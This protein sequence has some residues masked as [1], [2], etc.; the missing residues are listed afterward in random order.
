MQLFILRQ[1]FFSERGPLTKTL[2]VMKITAFFLLF[3]CLQLGARGLYGQEKIT[4]NLKSASLETV[5]K[6]IRKQT[7][8]QY[9][10][11]DQWEQEAKKIDI[12]VSN[13][14]LSEVLDLCF[15]D[16]PFSYTIIKKMI[17]I[18]KKEEG[19]RLD[20][21]VVPPATVNFKGRVT[22]EQGE[23]LI[24]ASVELK[25][26]K[27]GTLTDEKGMF[28]LKDVPSDAILAVSHTGYQKKEIPLNG[29]SSLIIILGIAN[30]ILDQVKV[31]AYGTTTQ[32]LSTGNVSTVKAEDIEKQPVSNPLAALEG[33][34]PGLVIIQNSG[35]PGSGFNVQIRG[36][37]SISN[38]TDPLY[39]I[40]GVP[41][42]STPLNATFSGQIIGY[43]SPLSYINPSDIE[44]IEVLKDA[45]ATAIYG[46]RGANG[47]I[48]ITTKKGKTG[49]T[50]VD[51][52][53]YTG[54]EKTTR[55]MTLLNTQQY[56]QMRHEAFNNDGIVP[57]T[58]N[59]RDLL[60]WDTTRYTDWQKVLIGGTAHITNAQASISG[61]NSNTHFFLG[62]GYMRETTVFNGN[63][64]DQKGS[65]H[66]NLS[67][68]SE[69]HKL[70]I[71]YSGSYVQDKDNLITRDITPY[72]TLPPD[73]PSVY[74]SSG[75]LNWG[76]SN[77]LFNNNPYSFLKQKFVSKGN[78]LLTNA[79]LKYQLFS[80][81][82]LKTSLGYNQIQV[83]NIATYPQSSYSPNIQSFTQSTSYFSNYSVKS[84]II[85]PQVEYLRN[86]SGGILNAIF[87]TTF[88]EKIS[89]DQEFSA[90]GFSNEALMEN[91]S[92]ATNIAAQTSAY[93]Q[94]RYSAAFGRINYNWKERYL[95]TFTGRRDGSS[96][97]GPG[98]QFANF[99]S[100]G[101]SW[102][103]TNESF[104]KSIPF[105]SLGK[106][107][108]SYGTAGNDQIP[109]YGFLNTYSSTIY[110][111][112]GNSGLVPTRL[113]NANYSWETIKKLEAAIELGLLRDRL[114]ISAI[115]Y[116]SR[117]SN[118]LVGFSL[119]AITGFPSIQANLPALIQN[120]SWEFML[121]TSNIKTKTVEWTTTAN[122][123]IPRNKLVSYPNL[124]SSSYANT[125][126]IG[127][128]LS[129]QKKFHYIGV[130][131]QGG[132]YSFATKN[133]NGLPSYPVDLQ[134]V[135]KVA[136]SFYGGVQNHI[137]YKGFQLDILIQ[138]VKQTGYNYLYGGNFSAPGTMINQPDFVMTRWQK[139]GDI[140][141]IQK[142]TQS[143]SIPYIYNYA[144]SDNIISDASFIRL[145]NLSFSYNLPSKEIKK[146]G[147][148][149][150]R[151]YLQG[152]NLL[153]FTHY[154]GFD[155]ENNGGIRLPPL[156][157]ITGGIQF[158]F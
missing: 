43:G 19:K 77:G 60:L 30:N 154:V 74:D 63:F 89:E 75:N 93:S 157:V 28:E 37:N 70:S 20:Q 12:S 40:D 119:P 13:A 15:K 123:T 116:R 139:P 18:K 10:F 69:N 29:E 73:A 80:G 90:T 32:R 114:L 112:D 85:E 8:Y 14:S 158:I 102:I 88:Q 61:G 65:L 103:F 137:S 44:S 55:M 71:T 78:N 149:S 49:P 141:N 129:I 23:P 91:I 58:T 108:G 83:E 54:Y 16:Q 144:L 122:L 22:N 50:K 140:T 92:S 135:K 24:G 45:D 132:T 87:G 105:L 120:T 148:Q 17:V 136:Q 155:P 118:Q 31:I 142:F 34:V 52:N 94:Y 104:A 38:G 57:T 152:Q 25:K 128:P 147:I 46:S 56:L 156:R 6:D 39:I 59:A 67:H 9:L 111:Y 126:V 143:T 42:T 1:S 150:C 124:A 130:D 121:T 127:E 97:F 115:W 113:F 101:A 4:I 98:Q 66:F 110:P 106:F 96:R 53:T 151:L 26:G 41:F 36:R 82:Y 68:I 138:F 35:V 86:I 7:G 125:Y 95:V 131:P 81:L 153:T 145:K 33:R 51:F 3:G 5:L 84:W 72:L 62:G 100:L 64:S 117:S 2:R 76:P 47:I 79:L 99:G 133:S 27:K 109:D 11:V 21:I 48:L 134:T 146:V 107:R